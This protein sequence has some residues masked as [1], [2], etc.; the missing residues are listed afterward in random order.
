LLSHLHCDH[1]ADLPAVVLG[2]TAGRDKS[3]PLPVYLPAGEG[4]RLQ[5]WLAACG[6][7]FVLERMALRELAY[8]EPAAIGPFQVAMGRAAHSLPAGLFVL[9]AAG[10][11]FVYTGDTGDSP[12]LRAAM[13]GADLLLAEATPL[14]P[15]E[16]AAKG[17]LTAPALGEM[18]R[19]AGV[20]RLLVTHFMPGAEP[21]AIA[22]SVAA[23]FGG[24]VT[25]A[26][27]GLRLAI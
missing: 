27:E 22:E 14:T 13:I 11:R 17:H 8:D 18:A 3:D 19:A 7:T 1:S 15:E 6:F 16:A 20:R 24:P 26:R 12:A 23:A 4:E 21:E 2:A 25:P 10:R 5:R 9:S